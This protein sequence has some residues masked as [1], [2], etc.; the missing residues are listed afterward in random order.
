MPQLLHVNEPFLLSNYH[1][2][3]ELHVLKSLDL[4]KL[5]KLHYDLVQYKS[6]TFIY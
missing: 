6:V 5:V 1:L 3:V 4:S 2:H